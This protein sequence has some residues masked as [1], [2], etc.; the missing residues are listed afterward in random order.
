MNL[1]LHLIR[2]DLRALRWPLLLWIAACLT[3]LGLRLAQFARGDG[4]TLT[5]FWRRLESTD[6]WDHLA[7][8]ILPILIVPLL[9]HLDPLRGALSFWKSVP[10]SR[11]R[12]LT[13]KSFTLLAF[14]VALPFA[15][16]VVYFVKAGL[17]IVLA[18]ALAD[19]A[20][21][22]LPG[23][24]AI[25]LG[26][27][28]TRSLKVGVPGVAI[29]LWLAA[30]TFQWPYS[31]DL[32]ANPLLGNAGPKPPGII[33]APP[34]SHFEIEQKSVQFARMNVTEKEEPGKP[35]HTEERIVLL[36]KC[37]TS[38]LPENVIV[39]SVHLQG[40]SIHLPGRVLGEMD[41]VSRSP[42]VDPTGI[43][44]QEQ[45]EELG[46]TDYIN[47]YDFRDLDASVWKTQSNYFRMAAKDLPPSGALVE[48]KVLI[49][50]ARRRL[51][52][53]L[54]LEEGAQWRP[55]LHRF[56][57]SQVSP[58][59]ASA[60]DFRATL[61]TVLADPRGDTGALALTPASNF[62]LWIEHG[63]LPYRKHLNVIPSESW[64]AARFG[65]DIT[66]S[67]RRTEFAPSFDP[68]QTMSSQATP[69]T[70]AR[71]A[72]EQA[73]VR[74][75]HLAL[76]AYD[77]IGTVEIPLKA[78]APRPQIAREETES[79]EIKPPQPSLGITLGEIVV[80]K[81]PSRADAQKIFARIVEL[82]APRDVDSIRRHEQV[83]LRK[84]TAL[85]ADNLEVLL[86]AATEA[87][88]PPR[89]SENPPRQRS[90]WLLDWPDA[91]AFWR[92]V[93]I[94]ACDLARP[95][96]KATILR[97]HSP[98]VD[99]LRAIEPNGWEADALPGMWRMA[100]TARVSPE[101][102]D[103][104]ARHPGPETKAAL[105]AQ[106]RHRAIRENRVAAWIANGVLPGREAAGELW[107]TAVASTGNIRELTPAFPLAVRHGVEIVPRD[108]VRILRLPHLDFSHS[109]GAA[110]KTWQGAF[111]QSFSLRSDCPTAFAEA[112]PWLEENALVAQ[113]NDATGRY[114]LPGK[115]T[116][117]PDLSGW[118][119][120]RD[121]IG[122]GRARLDGGALVLSTA[123]VPGEFEHSVENR[124]A[125]RVLREVEGDFTAEVTVTPAYDLSRSLDGREE[126]IFQSVGMVLEAGDQ[127]WI[128][129]QHG[130][131]KTNDGHE[132]LE[133]LFRCGKRVGTQRG[134]DK[135]DR[136]KPLRMRIA[137]HG[138]FFSTA[139]SQD[140]GAWVESP[141]RLELGW[142]RK[143]RVGLLVVN[144]AARPLHAR[145][146]DFT[147]LPTSAAPADPFA[148]NPHGEPTPTG[149][150][151]GELGTVENPIGAGIFKMEDG[152]LSIDVAPKNSDY[153]IEQQ[154]TAPRVMNE[155]E[156]DFSF[157]ATI[158]PTPK[159][160]WSSAE[161]LLA[162]GADYYLRLGLA[163]NNHRMQFTHD[164]AERGWAPGMP[165]LEAKRDLTKPI[166]IRLVRR[167]R[168]LTIAHQQEEGEWTEFDPLNFQHW[169]AKIQVGVV[170]LNTSDEPFTAVFSDVKLTQ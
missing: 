96:D 92:R 134:T 157:E 130:L 162:A 29:A 170:A 68:I 106:I 41:G 40:A 44:A 73:Q 71:F 135:W 7:L 6:R 18:R 122:S 37:H 86:G 85:G 132:L 13:A 76:H 45:R 140:G 120:F 105:L 10:I 80:P 46:H 124:T 89:E 21:R 87:L 149:T 101:W 139:W 153:N 129:L 61:A 116:P 165:G 57:L 168:F 118:G 152:T 55:G 155:V 52:T 138:D 169:P 159:H 12:L 145:F 65:C 147:L 126:N 119:E 15:C 81:N 144:R 141:A 158:A 60:A 59:Q 99:L 110:F 102:Q 8:I 20:W 82:A 39:N 48:G 47:E 9:L 108:L 148:P 30:I 114:E 154:M 100:A 109:N 112:A 74:N 70:V 33:A 131:W 88:P 54:P 32:M 53:T 137:R 156:G 146:T 83:L 42:R 2:K 150:K 4:S 94:A 38:G 31:R 62:A 49:S 19:W 43:P 72:E 11:G 107:E 90:E 166:R 125:P 36:L 63:A 67:R 25:V 117:A 103:C 133:V 3:H 34:G 58:P 160:S 97:F 93:I 95:A 164:Y 104:F 51:V 163:S 35:R 69:L 1:T 121:V 50:L 161:L 23:L 115:S 56:T 17:S 66:R 113:F 142:P 127:R 22:F 98:T 27:A 143:V 128:R 167:G 136:A 123:G 28:F 84:L 79:D 91:P 26:C 77:D 14:F 78:V 24:A 5:P 111:V 151:L 75:W 16:E 64:R